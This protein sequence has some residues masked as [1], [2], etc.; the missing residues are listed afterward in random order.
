M[1]DGIHFHCGPQLPHERPP[2]SGAGWQGRGSKVSWRKPHRRWRLSPWRESRWRWAQAHHGA[3]GVERPCSV[4]TWSERVE[5]AG[6]K[7]V[8][9]LDA[10]GRLGRRD[11]RAQVA[12]RYTSRSLVSAPAVHHRMSRWR[13]TFRRWGAQR[14]FA[15]VA[16]QTERRTL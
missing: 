5:A 1:L 3:P 8:F 4:G 2:G 10:C 14:G 7:E 16:E 12:L 9:Y 15:L 11:E 6:A 13:R